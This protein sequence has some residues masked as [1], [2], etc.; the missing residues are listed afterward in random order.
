LNG[1]WADPT[2]EIDAEH[3]DEARVVTMGVIDD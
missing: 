3:A 2:I 1:F